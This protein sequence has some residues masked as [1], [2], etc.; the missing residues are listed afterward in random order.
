[1]S[2]PRIGN[3]TK[4]TH[5]AVAALL[6]AVGED[7]DDPPVFPRLAAVVAVGGAAFGRFLGLGI[8]QAG[9]VID[10]SIGQLRDGALAGAV[11]RKR[12][13]GLPA[14]AAVVAIDGRVVAA[15]HAEDT[16]RP[17]QPASLLAVP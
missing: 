17:Q 1:M 9:V 15:L 10:A 4:P 6:R 13:A 2:R 14:F 12:G 16:G 11:F 7:F 3:R 8:V 5:A